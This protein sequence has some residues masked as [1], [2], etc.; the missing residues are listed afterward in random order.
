MIII[1]ITV[2]PVSGRSALIIDVH[3]RIHC[4]IKSQAEKGRAN[5]EVVSLLAEK[6]GITKSEVEIVSGETVRKKRIR[7][8]TDITMEQLFNRCGLSKQKTV[9]E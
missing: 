7:I 8:N 1:E 6:I 5:K 3:G 9:F 4:Y 2:H